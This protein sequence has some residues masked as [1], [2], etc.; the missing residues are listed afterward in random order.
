[1][2][3]QA[4]IQLVADNPRRSWLWEAVR[5]PLN[6]WRH[7]P[8]TALLIHSLI[9]T[10]Q[11]F[12]SSWKLSYRSPSKKSRRYEIM[13]GLLRNGNF[14]LS[15]CFWESLAVT[16]L[17]HSVTE[18][19]E[20]MEKEKLVKDDSTFCPHLFWDSHSQHK[21]CDGLFP[22]TFAKWVHVYTFLVLRS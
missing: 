16:W 12:P 15:C 19:L 10:A 13:C 14:F 17:T 6:V 9:T 18:A 5:E 2:L 20:V 8:F 7:C 11:P 4:C 22:M 1:M 21:I 3:S